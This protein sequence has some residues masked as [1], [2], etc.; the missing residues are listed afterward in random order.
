MELFFFLS[1]DALAGKLSDAL[2]EAMSFGADDKY[3]FA[4]MWHLPVNKDNRLCAGDINT[5]GDHPTLRSRNLANEPGYPLIQLTE[6]NS[7][8]W[9]TIGTVNE[10]GIKSQ[11]NDQSVFFF[12]CFYS[13][14]YWIHS[15]ILV[16]VY[17]LK[18]N[19]ADGH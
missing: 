12:L 16:S 17:N 13:W 5:Q 2:T 6:S 10:W 14:P 8:E 19:I 9:L 7:P 3:D 1:P 18:R 4:A 15:S 11:V